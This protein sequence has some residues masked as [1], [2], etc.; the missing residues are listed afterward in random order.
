MLC[1]RIYIFLIFEE[2]TS[3]FLKF[4][5]LPFVKL[6]S[7]P[8]SQLNLALGQEMPVSHT[9]MLCPINKHYQPGAVPLTPLLLWTSMGTLADPLQIIGAW[10]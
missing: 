10:H 4:V 9:N 7:S 1:K 8:L 5:Q 3:F 2:N 6:K